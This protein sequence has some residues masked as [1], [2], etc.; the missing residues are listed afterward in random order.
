ME[1]LRLEV[2]VLQIAQEEE[3]EP[4]EE[5]VQERGQEVEEAVFCVEALEHWEAA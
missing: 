2:E 1:E 3:E 5:V 4:Q